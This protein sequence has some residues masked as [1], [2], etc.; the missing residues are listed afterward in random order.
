MGAHCIIL[1]FIPTFSVGYLD[2]EVLASFAQK[3]LVIRHHLF[4]Q[5]TV[6]TL[7]CHMPHVMTIEKK[8]E[9]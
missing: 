7:W 5:V 2:Q 6:D 8:H 9:G 3:K 1:I 4:C